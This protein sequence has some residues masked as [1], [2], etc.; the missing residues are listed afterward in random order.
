MALHLQAKPVAA[1]LRAQLEK[2]A[3]QLQQAGILPRLA[4]LLIG[5]NPASIAYA[6]AKE[7]AADRAGISFRLHAF[8]DQATEA[9][10]LERLD[11]LNRD[12]TVHGILVE[13]PL[14]KRFDSARILESVAPHKDVDGIHPVNRGRLFS[15]QEAFVPATAL[16]CI[17]LLQ[18][19]Q[20]PISGRHAVVVGRGPTVGRPL[21]ALL[22][23]ENATVTVCHSRSGALA[24]YTRKAELLFAA[25]GHRHLISAEMVAPGAVVIDAGLSEAPDGSLTGDVDFASV[26][27]IAGAITPVPGGVGALT[28]LLLL[29]NVIDAAEAALHDQLS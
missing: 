1:V 21:L 20:I 12:P 13:W 26:E 11:A 2:R 27:P 19:Y 14:P 23:K 10:I 3:Q 28:T 15:G 22:L 29:Q 5:D 8:S 25:T 17:A 24:R 7:R 18:H 9:E 6:K 16:A 4:V